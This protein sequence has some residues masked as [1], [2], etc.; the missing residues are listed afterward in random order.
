MYETTEHGHR[1]TTGKLLKFANSIVITSI[2]STFTSDEN[3]MLHKVP[4]LLNTE[5]NVLKIR[6]NLDSKI[7]K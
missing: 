3:I 7:R 6:D 2:I 1:K 4:F 5:Q